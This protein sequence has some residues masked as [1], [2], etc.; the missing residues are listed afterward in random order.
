[1]K[2][3]KKVLAVLLALAM[4]AGALSGCISNYV[5]TETTPAPTQQQT[6]APSQTPAET[7]KPGETAPPETE[8]DIS[9]IT[10]DVWYAVS[11][12]SGEELRSSP[13]LSQSSTA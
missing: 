11:G 6:Q 8:P 9:G 7:A 12:T 3:L 10:L 2:N 4:T 1:M 5:H 13:K